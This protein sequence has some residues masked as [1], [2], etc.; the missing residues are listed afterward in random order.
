MFWSKT[1]KTVVYSVFD[2]KRRGRGGER[3]PYHVTTSYL[4][5]TPRGLLN[6]SRKG[7]ACVRGKKNANALSP[8]CTRWTDAQQ[9]D[10]GR[11]ERTR[12][13][14]RARPRHGAWRTPSWL[15]PS[16]FP[17]HD[18]RRVELIE[19]HVALISEVSTVSLISETESFGAR[20]GQNNNK[21]QNARTYY[22]TKKKPIKMT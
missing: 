7:P 10:R 21:R 4:S 19:P 2:K 22:S 8:H 13:R 1:D 16:P 3:L 20:E 11:R 6:L 14:A 15:P 5:F 12:W 9:D 18:R 17:P